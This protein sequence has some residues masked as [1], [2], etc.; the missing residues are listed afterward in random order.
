[1]IFY[2]T[3]RRN[4]A[5]CVRAARHFELSHQRHYFAACCGAERNHCFELRETG[6]DFSLRRKSS[7]LKIAAAFVRNDGVAAR[8][9]ARRAFARNSNYNNCLFLNAVGF[10]PVIFLNVLLK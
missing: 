6:W 9:F 8:V 5:M 3:Q 7:I 1:M 4:G 2:F 10:S